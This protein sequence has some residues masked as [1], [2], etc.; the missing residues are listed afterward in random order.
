MRK[1]LLAITVA[2]LCCVLAVPIAQAAP[3]TGDTKK[4][5]ADIVDGRAVYQS[6]PGE[7]TPTGSQVLAQMDLGANA[8][9]NLKYTMTVLASDT[10]PTVLATADA[11]R[12][13][14]TGNP[15]TPARVQFDAPLP[16]PGPEGLV[17]IAITTTK[18]NGQVLDAAPDTG[19]VPIPID[20]DVSGATKFR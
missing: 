1:S 8:C 13:P 15:L 10:D 4:A 11:V 7:V 20:S 6:V 17:C 12:I 2:L 9:K 19:C 18:K 14:A 3:S 5:C 16:Y